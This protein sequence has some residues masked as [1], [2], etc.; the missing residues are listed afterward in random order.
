M[1]EP[2][3]LPTVLLVFVAA[4]ATPCLAANEQGYECSVPPLEVKFAIATTC[5]APGTATLARGN[6][7]RRLNRRAPVRSTHVCS[8][9]FR[10]AR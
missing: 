5:P 8:A 7:L 2:A 1:I 10:M 4:S 9:L 3:R 6:F